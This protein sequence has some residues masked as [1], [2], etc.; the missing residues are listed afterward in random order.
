MS[1]NNVHI[2]DTLFSIFFYFVIVCQILLGVCVCL[3][4]TVKRM[5]RE[6]HVWKLLG[7]AQWPSG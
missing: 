6:I 1:I 4:S 5:K 2:T 7:L 3:K